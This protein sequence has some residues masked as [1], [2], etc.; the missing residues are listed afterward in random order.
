MGETVEDVETV[1]PALEQ[2]YRHYTGTMPG[3]DT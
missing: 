3:A 1:P 2:L